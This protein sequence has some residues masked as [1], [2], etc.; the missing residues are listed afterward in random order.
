[1]LDLD[2][3]YFVSKEYCSLVFIKV[4][5]GCSCP[6]GCWLGVSRGVVIMLSDSLKVVSSSWDNWS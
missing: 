6:F 4:E 1:M 3:K 2:Y 5:L